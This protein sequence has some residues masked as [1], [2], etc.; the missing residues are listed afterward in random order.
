MFTV[1]RA[2]HLVDDTLFMAS[3]WSLAGN[4]TELVVLPDAGHM[5]AG[6]PSVHRTWVPQMVEFLSAALDG[7]PHPE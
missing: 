1:G 3:R 6:L 5:A 7:R 4:R 2:D